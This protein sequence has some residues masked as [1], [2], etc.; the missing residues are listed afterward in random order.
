MKIFVCDMKQGNN[1]TITYN[2]EDIFKDIPDDPDNVLMVIPPEVLERMG[3]QMGDT[4]QIQQSEN[5]SITITKAPS[6]E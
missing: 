1:M 5:G 4:L 3:W 2:V 6:N